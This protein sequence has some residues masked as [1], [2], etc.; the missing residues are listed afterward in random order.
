[1][2]DIAGSLWSVPADGHRDAVERLRSAGLRRLHWDMSDGRFANPGGFDPDRARAL[3]HSAGLA[4][5]AHL[6][7]VDPLRHVDQWTDFCDLVVVHLESRNWREAV[8]R[9]ASRGCLPGVA[10]SPTTPAGA[11]PAG[12][13]VLCMTIAP[14]TAG[15]AFDEGVLL[16]LPALRRQS[17]RRRLG[18]DGGVRRGHVE[19]A[20]Q[21]GVDWLVVGT[22]LFRD[23]GPLVWADLLAEPPA[24]G[25]QLSRVRPTLPGS[26]RVR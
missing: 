3:T 2:P 16:K 8:D 6:M 4:A 21:S 15:S 18:L 7:A 22:D 10:I 19:R 20:E 23:G 5:E 14:G 9:I 12:L 26:R 11:A 13:P 17:P 24:T 25:E 1:M